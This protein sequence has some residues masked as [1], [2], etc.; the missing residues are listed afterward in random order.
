MSLR[1][2]CSAELSYLRSSRSP[3][4]RKRRSFP[5]LIRPFGEDLILFRNKNGEPGVLSPRCS[6][7]GTSLLYGRSR[8]TAL[9]PHPTALVPRHRSIRR[10]LRLPGS[11]GY[12][13]T[14]RVFSC[15]ERLCEDEEIG[16]ARLLNQGEIQPFPLDYN[17]VPGLRERRGSVIVEVGR[18]VEQTQ[19]DGIGHCAIS[20]V[21]WM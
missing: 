2:D 10:D 19:V 21:V 16:V 17:W 3:C 5:K 11:T 7:R 13:A 15:F 14:L 18:P 6:H 9:G 8:R 20:R 1:G 12:T 4:P